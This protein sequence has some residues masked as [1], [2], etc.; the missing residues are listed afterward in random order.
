MMRT[1]LLIPGPV[2]IPED[3]REAMSIPSMPHYG[4]AWMQLFGQTQAMAKQLFATQ[5]DLYIMAGPGSMALEAALG[6]ALE[7]GD[8]VLVPNNGFF[9][10]R[11]VAMLEGLAL[12][13]LQVH[14][15]WGQ[16]LRPEHLTETLATHPELKAMAVVHHET[17][18]G[19]L[20]PLESLCAMARDQDLLIVVDAV[21]SLGGVSLPVDAWGID[22]CVTVGNKVLETPPALALLSISPRAW[23]QIMQRQA[24]RG[25]YLDLR[26]WRWYADNWGDWHPT[27]VTMPT[28]NLYALHHSLTQL[29]AQ[30]IPQ[31]W[32]AY[33]AAMYAVRRGLEAV[34]CTM[35]VEEA[36]A[37]PLTTAFYPPEGISAQQM[38][39]WLNDEAKLMI[40]GGLG[41]L[42]GKILRV[43]HIGLA[44]QRD[45]VEPFLLA[46]ENYLR[47]Q[48]CEVLPGSSLVA[49]EMVTQ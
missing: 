38:Q 22:C 2:D 23:E 47:L 11:I 10:D 34:G 32:K 1:K 35:L 13:P 41:A 14:I 24:P 16:P 25:W 3:V 39:G 45:Y 49:L 36:Y 19:V 44:R 21:S 6:S 20:N 5:H 43:G 31:R 33:A 15:P 9:A 40:T 28:S 17:S 4:A 42:K 26:M 46:V 27:P 29:L 8:A 37:S 30:G 12:K 7:P 18:T 48:G